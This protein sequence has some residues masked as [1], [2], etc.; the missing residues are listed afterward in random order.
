[1][2]MRKK[3]EQEGGG[4]ARSLDEGDLDVYPLDDFNSDCSCI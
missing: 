2:E 1:M 3:R 4:T